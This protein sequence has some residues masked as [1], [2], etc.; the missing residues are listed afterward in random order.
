MR[1]EAS[2]RGKDVLVPAENSLAEAVGTWTSP[3]RFQGLS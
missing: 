1:F 3:P 2:L